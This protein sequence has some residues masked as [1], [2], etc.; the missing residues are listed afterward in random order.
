M[1]HCPL[2]QGKGHIRIRNFTTTPYTTGPQCFLGYPA[3]RNWSSDDLNSRNFSKTRSAEQVRDFF[4]G[5]LFFGSVIEFLSICNVSAQH[6]DF[7]T[8]DGQYVTTKRLPQMLREWKKVAQERLRYD[9]LII[10]TTMQAALIL[11]T[12]R[13]FVD[14][15][16]LPRGGG[17]GFP[18][19]VRVQLV[20]KSPLPQRV[21]MSIIALGHALTSAMINGCDIRRTGSRWGGSIMLEQRM[22]AKGW[23][24]LDVRRTFFDHS[25]SIYE[26]YYLSKMQNKDKSISHDTC[27]EFECRGRNVDEATYRQ[28]H[29]PSCHGKCGG[30][31]YADLER[32]TK[33]IRDGDIPVFKWNLQSNE[34]ELKVVKVNAQGVGEPPFMAISHV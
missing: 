23:C 20:A 28:L 9:P 14:D 29:A 19:D 2:P 5:W 31:Q 4:Q 8:E 33:V 1:N 7:L 24:P 17:Q 21:W 22:L 13:D 12:V 18:A 32:L 6:S 15:Y 11:G 3:R 16:C 34:L 26:Q 25:M 27:T 10:S 30:F